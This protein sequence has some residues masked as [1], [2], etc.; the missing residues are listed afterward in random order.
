MNSLTELV[1]KNKKVLDFYTNHPSLDFEKTNLL[2]VNF[3]ET[4]FNHITDDLETNV[5]SQLLSFMSKNQTQLEEL[6]EQLSSY[7]NDIHNNQ[8]ETIN[9]VFSNLSSWKTQYIE[10]VKQAIQEGKDTT[11]IEMRKPLDVNTKSFLGGLGVGAL[12]LLLL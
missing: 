9:S 1:C 6:Q 7:K 3:M 10:D 2:F 5:N 4:F 8:Q 11:E 12:L